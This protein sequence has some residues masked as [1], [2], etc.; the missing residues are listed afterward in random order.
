[1]DRYS[2]WPLVKP[3]RKLDTAAVITVLE[4]WFLEHGKPINL[5]SD[6]GPQFRREF[7]HW[8]KQEKINH[9]LSSAYHHQ[10]NGHAEVA[11]REMKNLLAKTGGNF[12]EFRRALREWRNTPRFDGLSP[13]QWLM[14]YRQRT[15][16]IAAP[17]AYQ[18][19]SDTQLKLHESLRGKQYEKVKESKPS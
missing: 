2:G 9:E 12:K 7:D 4:D 10:S 5:R 19:I 1:M 14:G 17:A 18:K 16:A 6:G 8:C 15:E 13:A 3:L 11:V